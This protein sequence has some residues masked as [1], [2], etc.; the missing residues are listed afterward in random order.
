MKVRI[1]QRGELRI[2]LED[3][4]DWGLLESLF[5]DIQLTKRPLAERMGEF[6]TDEGVAEDWQDLV[7]P[8][9]NVRFEGEVSCVADAIE[10]AALSSDTDEGSILIRRSDAMQWY[11][12]LN[13]ARLSLEEHYGFGSAEE[14]DPSEFSAD[15][16]AAFLRGQL[17]LS[18]QSALLHHVL[19]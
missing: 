6:V 10:K 7:V 14:L 3:L 2:D 13:Q 15:E 8:D 17:Y 4:T 9:L 19:Q 5:Q 18:I 11:G 16:Y 1:T 12:A